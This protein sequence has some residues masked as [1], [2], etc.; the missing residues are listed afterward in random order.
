MWG[1]SIDQ[2]YATIAHGARSPTD[3]DT[4]YNVMPN[5][6]TDGILDT[7]QLDLLS[8]QVASLSGIEGGAASPRASSCS[9]TTAP[10]ATARTVAA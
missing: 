3:G 6:G 7:E 1:G 8:Q 9:P 10:A 2:I 4:H 5:F